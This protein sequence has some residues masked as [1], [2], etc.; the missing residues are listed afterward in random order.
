MI[1][2]NFDKFINETSSQENSNS[3]ELWIKNE[4]TKLKNGDGS[5]ILELGKVGDFSKTDIENIKKRYRDSIVF[6]KDG[7]YL[8]KINENLKNI[9]DKL[10]KDIKEEIKENNNLTLDFFNVIK[11]EKLNENEKSYFN[12]NEDNIIDIYQDEF[13]VMIFQNLNEEH[14][15]MKI[16]EEIQIDLKYLKQKIRNGR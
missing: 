9:I 11:N 7:K 14:K 8:L 13:D 6:E 1:V 12:K 15:F 10:D 4:Y 2:K 16:I 3:Y 5:G